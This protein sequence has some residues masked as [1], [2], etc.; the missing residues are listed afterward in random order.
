MNIVGSSPGQDSAW[1]FRDTG[2]SFYATR[3]DHGIIAIPFPSIKCYCSCRWDVGYVMRR[4]PL[5]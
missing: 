2:L 5:F 1:A 4:A 3:T